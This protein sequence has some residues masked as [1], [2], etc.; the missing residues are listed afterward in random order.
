M[1]DRKG[2]NDPCDCGS[3]KKYKDCCGAPKGERVQLQPK[4]LKVIELTPGLADA[5][6]AS[7]DPSYQEYWVAAVSGKSTKAAADRV[8]AIPEDKR[9]LTRVL[10]S[11]DNAFADFD[12]ETVKLDLPYMQQRK[13][14][15]I[16]T[17][18]S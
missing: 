16:R 5:L 7:L 15:A 3:G 4:D 9:Y 14:E 1:S 2:R 8:S 11:L 12:N 13:P 18:S 6:T 10:G 17:Y